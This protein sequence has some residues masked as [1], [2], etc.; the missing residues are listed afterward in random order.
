MPRRALVYDFYLNHMH[1]FILYNYLASE[2][3]YRS[4]TSKVIQ[5]KKRDF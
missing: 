4:L 3:L 1:P 5:L 2:N